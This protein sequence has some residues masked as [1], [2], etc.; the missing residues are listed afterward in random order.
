MSLKTGPPRERS[1]GAHVSLGRTGDEL[2]RRGLSPP[3]RGHSP[4]GE[5][6]RSLL[7]K[8]FQPCLGWVDRLRPLSLSLARL[9]LRLACVNACLALALS[10][11]LARTSRA[12]QG[13]TRCPPMLG[14]LKVRRILDEETPHQ[15][16]GLNETR[17]VL[18]E[19]P[20]GELEEG[21]GRGAVRWGVVKVCS[22]DHR[23][24][25]L[26][27]FHREGMFI[28]EGLGESQ[29][30][31]MRCRGG[32]VLTRGGRT[33]A[34]VVGLACGAVADAGGRRHLLRVSFL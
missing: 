19:R 7:C 15:L 5:A 33:V 23:E 16:G 29:S 26:V 10:L 14:W 12:E 8:G 20:R 1:Y 11:S 28:D 21:R 6:F 4:L 34:A 2:G 24:V 25:R 17:G 22:G 30:G 27:A 13:S 9:A 18:V 3:K 32:G 31:T